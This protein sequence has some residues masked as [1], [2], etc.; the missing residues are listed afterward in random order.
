MQSEDLIPAG[1][2]CAVHRVELSFIR[3]L[4]DSGLIGMTIRD[5]A[6]YLSSGELPELEKFVTWY[7]ELAINP[8]GIEAIAH[9]LG[10]MNGLL[11]ENRT[12]RNKLQ[13][14][15]SNAGGPVE[16]AEEV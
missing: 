1:E 7:Y 11:E 6:V 14:Y 5:G 10:R 9:L 16:P 4:H 13:G 15:E 12:L 2:F 3:N 8:E